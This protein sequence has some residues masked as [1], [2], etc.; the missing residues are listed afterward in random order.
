MT[1]IYIV[2]LQRCLFLSLQVEGPITVAGLLH[3]LGLGKYNV[4]FQ[5]EEVSNLL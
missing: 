3:T 1:S 4:L 5:A 2:I